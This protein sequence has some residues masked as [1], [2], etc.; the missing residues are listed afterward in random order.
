MVSLS[1]RYSCAPAE[2]LP[3]S[4]GD[5]HQKSTQRAKTAVLIASTWNICSM[6]DTEGPIEVASQSSNNQRGEA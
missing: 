1:I 5:S 6:V 2:V 3:A 4:Q